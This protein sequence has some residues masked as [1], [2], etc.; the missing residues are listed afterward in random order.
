VLS[1]SQSTSTSISG[2]STTFQ[3]D[4]HYTVMPKNAGSFTLKAHIRYNGQAY[5]TNALEVTVGEGSAAAE[6]AAQDIFVATTLPRAETY[7]GEKVIVSYELFSRYYIEN[8]GFTDNTAIDGMITKEIP[9]EQLTVEYVYLDG[10]RYA[11]YEIKQLILDPIKSGAQTIPSFNL[12]V[13]IITE[14]SSGGFFGGLLNRSRPVYLQTEAKELLVKPLPT[15][16]RPKDFSGIVGQLQLQGNYSRQE[17]NYGDSLSL[18][19]VAYGNCNLD[20]LKKA[21]QGEIP[22]FAVYETSK[23]TTESIKDKAYYVQKEFEAILVPE[24]NGAI[25]IAPISLSYFDPISEKYQRAQIEGVTIEVLGDMPQLGDGRGGTTVARETVKIAQVNYSGSDDGYLSLR[26]NKKVLYGVA[27]GLAAL[28]VLAVV[29]LGLMRRQKKQDQTLKSLYKQ[30]LASQDAN[31]AYSLFC[32]M[33]KHRYGLSLKASSQKAVLNN[34]PEP[35]LAAQV[36]EI[37][38]HMELSAAKDCQYLQD[39]IR[40]VYRMLSRPA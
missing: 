32:A 27:I 16:G 28:L 9:L 39:K 26:L 19:I 17:V 35:A 25:D 8:F 11:K 33:I 21:V 37:M 13:N 15:T 24:K 29:A 4:L 12:Q 6:G 22:G 31:E 36:V 5:E 3:T 23:N 7:V 1:Q 40:G 18:Q 10:V 14:E 20:G 30:A 38:D 34:L 2:L